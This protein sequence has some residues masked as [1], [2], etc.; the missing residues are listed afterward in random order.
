[1]QGPQCH[2]GSREPS[3][4]CLGLPP[5]SDPAAHHCKVVVDELDEVE[6]GTVVEIQRNML[7]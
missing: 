3:D 4:A 5:A 6:V 7:V 2:L 1:M